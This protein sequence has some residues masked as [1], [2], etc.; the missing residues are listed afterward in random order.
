MDD[1]RIEFERLRL[2][3]T[4]EVLEDTIEWYKPQI[5]PQDCGWMHTT[6]S[7]LKHRIDE[8]KK[9]LKKLDKP[10]NKIKHRLSQ[11]S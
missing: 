4:I 2:I 5:E 10:K 9:E 3:N 11:K 6:I 8:A 7:G 1:Y